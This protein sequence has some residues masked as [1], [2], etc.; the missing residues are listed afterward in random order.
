MWVIELYEAFVDQFTKF[1]IL[2]PNIDL[3]LH[4][5]FSV[6]SDKFRTWKT[7]LFQT[8]VVCNLYCSSET[9]RGSYH[10]IIIMHEWSDFCQHNN[11]LITTTTLLSHEDN[12]KERFNSSILLASLFHL[13]IK[14]SSAKMGGGASKENKRNDTKAL[15]ENLQKFNPKTMDV[16][17]KMN[18]GHDALNALW[19]TFH[20]IGK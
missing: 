20:A 15:H 16:F 18:I 7:A 6:S 4:H 12:N 1:L 3:I 13:P 17:R 14:Q 19:K 11:T 5:F 2:I 9:L 10:H 8:I